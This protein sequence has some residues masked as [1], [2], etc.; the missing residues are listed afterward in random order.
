MIA[1]DDPGTIGRHLQARG[2]M[3][4]GDALTVRALAGGVSAEVLAVSTPTRELVVKRAL[5][6]LRVQEE[7]R[8]DV[9]RV[10]TEGRAL[11]LAGEL[12]PGAVPPVRDLDEHSHVLVMD[13]AP[14]AWTDWRD[15][16]LAGRVDSSLGR[17]LGTLLAGW[18]VGTARA[19]PLAE[20]ADT[21]VF[22]QL[23]V[24]PFHR[25]VAERHPDL[26][27][28]VEEVAARLLETKSCLVHGDFSPKN[29]LVAPARD[30][31]WVLDWEVAHIGDPA[32]DLAFMLTH[33]VLKAVHRS[34]H[35]GKYRDTAEA[36]L[37]GYG[38]AAGAEGL[39]GSHRLAAQVGCLLLARVDGKSPAGYLTPGERDR[40]R[41]LGR[42]L[43][44][45]PSG[46][47]LDAWRLPA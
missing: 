3:L 14:E 27:I 41:V 22:E 43:L 20:F 39:R 42:A 9:Q 30:E 1:L 46:D 17:V 35:A 15:D 10:V 45:A 26:S 16:L 12:I 37:D 25:T 7:W 21:S 44:R 8:A 13:R 33:L 40:V 23:R 4:D 32:F 38:A 24:D 29:I 19:L 2:L 6:R 5:P 18:H 34:T 11:R 47:I 31:V 36:F 28:H